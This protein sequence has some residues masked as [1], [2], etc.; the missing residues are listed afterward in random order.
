M[1]LQVLSDEGAAADGEAADESAAAAAVA[2]EGEEA[3]IS[4]AQMQVAA[5]AALAAAAAKARLMADAEEREIRRIVAEVRARVYGS[6]RDAKPYNLRQSSPRQALR[7]GLA[8]SW[9]EIVAGGICERLP[10]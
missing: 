5:A 4:P 8:R 1:T 7:W 9:L 3:P 10:S 2:A 6:L